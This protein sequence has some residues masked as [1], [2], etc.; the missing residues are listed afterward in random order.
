MDEPKRFSYRLELPR[1]K[2][3]RIGDLPRLWAEA[4]HD[5]EFARV[6]AAERIWRKLNDDV[7]SGALLPLCAFTR[8]PHEFPVGDALRRAVVLPEGLRPMLERAGIELALIEPEPGAAETAPPEPPETPKQRRA[9]LLAM[10]DAE[11]AAGRKRGALARITA[12]EKR[13]KLTADRSNIGKDIKKAR[14]ERDA[15]RRGG[16]LTRLLK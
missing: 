9:R 8:V 13:T 15:E 4:M 10:L 2:A 6:V 7:L 1:G 14:E 12:M 11:S 5:D 16:A 3:V